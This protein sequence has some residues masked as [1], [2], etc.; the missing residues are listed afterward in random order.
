M[1]AMFGKCPN[2]TI[3]DVRKYKKIMSQQKGDSFVCPVFPQKPEKKL[4]P[5][6]RIESESL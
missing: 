3:S 1:M 2:Y 4:E 5:D 6:F